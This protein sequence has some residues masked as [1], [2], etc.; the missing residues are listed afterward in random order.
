MGLF[1]VLLLAGLWVSLLLPGVYRERRELSR[2]DSP[3]SFQHAMSRLGR[4]CGSTYPVT[5][6]P[7]GRHILVL[8]DAESVVRSGMRRRQRAAL[9]Q[10]GSVVFVIGSLAV[11]VGGL[12]WTVFGISVAVFACYVLLVAQVRTR[13]AE[14]REKVRNLRPARPAHLTHGNARP[15]VRIQRWVG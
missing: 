2:I 13:Q 4:K 8:D 9:A 6:R 5:S 7:S 11:F 1:L 10:L 14:R 15:N 3:H 12:L